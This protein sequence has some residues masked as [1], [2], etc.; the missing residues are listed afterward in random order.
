MSKLTQR[1]SLSA[2]CLA[3]AA[4]LA[5]AAPPSNGATPILNGHGNWL[6]PDGATLGF[7]V[8]VVQLPSGEFHGSGRSY[9][10]ANNDADGSFKFE[11]L[12]AMTWDGDQAVL[13]VITDTVNTPPHIAVGTLV[14]LLVQDNGQGGGMTDKAI[15]ASGLP[16][17]L[18]LAD[19]LPSAP[20]MSEWPSLEAGNF[21]VH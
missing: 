17:F 19:I 13:G 2:L 9:R 12:D 4:L 5:A 1:L 14:A 6:A 16:S 10:R 3:G 8:N 20:P 15:S 7:Q 18:T 11:V 21:V